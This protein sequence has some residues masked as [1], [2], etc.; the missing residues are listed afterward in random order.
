MMVQPA[1][2]MA[3]VRQSVE[4]GG[5]SATRPEMVSAEME[6]VRARRIERRTG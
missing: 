6:V 5:S 1:P 2:S 4:Q 3:V